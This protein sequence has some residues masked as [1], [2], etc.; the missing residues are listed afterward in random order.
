MLYN[1]S[2]GSTRVMARPVIHG[3]SIMKMCWM[4]QCCQIFGH[5]EKIQPLTNGGH[6]TFEKKYYLMLLV[7]EYYKIS[8]IYRELEWTRWRNKHLRS[9]SPFRPFSYKIGKTIK[10][11]AADLHS[12]FWVMRPNN[13]P[14]GN[15]GQCM[16]C[17]GADVRVSY[18]ENPPNCVGGIR[19]LFIAD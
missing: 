14:V 16:Y 4:H 1:G 19:E 12:P 8:L 5:W 11:I 13:R 2:L 7:G 6:F 10:T 3:I 15:T 9:S 18:T 17:S